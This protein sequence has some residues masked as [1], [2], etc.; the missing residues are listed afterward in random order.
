MN[1]RVGPGE[2]QVDIA[3]EGIAE[4]PK[5]P[6]LAAA[7]EPAEIESALLPI[8]ARV[9]GWTRTTRLIE[10]RLIRRKPEP[11]LFFPSRRCPSKPPPGFAWPL[12]SG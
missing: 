5:L 10:A 8:V 1:R 2:G 7:L 9:I 6:C 4:D 12:P 3:N 11:S